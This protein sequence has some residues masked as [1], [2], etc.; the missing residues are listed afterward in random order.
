MSLVLDFLF[1][2]TFRTSG[3]LNFAFKRSN[4]R[5]SCLSF[6]YDLILSLFSGF[7]R[8][9]LERCAQLLVIFGASIL[10]LKFWLGF[11]WPIPEP[12]Y[13]SFPSCPSLQ[14]IY[15]HSGIWNIVVILYKYLSLSFL[16]RTLCAKL[17]WRLPRDGRLC[18]FLILRNDF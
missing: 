7:C 11:K 8:Y 9:D 14:D 6:S 16:S 13:H 17:A 2:V 12:E 10:T 18:T 1:I 4:F 15:C 3:L 5:R